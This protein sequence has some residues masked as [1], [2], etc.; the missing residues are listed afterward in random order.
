[1]EREYGQGPDYSSNGSR[2]YASHINPG[3]RNNSIDRHVPQGN[4]RH[5]DRDRERDMDDH[6]SGQNQY[7]YNYNGQGMNRT[8][9]GYTPSAR[10]SGS[11]QHFDTHLNNNNNGNRR[12][13]YNMNADPPSFPSINRNMENTYTYVKTTVGPSDIPRG[14]FRSTSESLTNPNPSETLK[15]YQHNT[16]QHGRD[17]DGV[18][19]F[20]GDNDYQGLG[21]TNAFF[22]QMYEKLRS[23]QGKLDGGFA[24]KNMGTKTT[25]TITRTFCEMATQTTEDDMPVSTYNGV[26]VVTVTR[27][28]ATQP[29]AVGQVPKSHRT[30]DQLPSHVARPS[31]M[32]RDKRDSRDVREMEPSRVQTIHKDEPRDYTNRQNRTSSNP[33]P[34]SKTETNQYTSDPTMPI[35][36][37]Y[38]AASDGWGNVAANKAV[39]EMVDW[40][41][42]AVAEFPE[43]AKPTKMTVTH[44][45]NQSRF[46]KAPVQPLPSS[47]G[48]PKKEEPKADQTHGQPSTSNLSWNN[49]RNSTQPQGRTTQETKPSNED[50]WLSDHR[51]EKTSTAWESSTAGRSPQDDQDAWVTEGSN[52]NRNNNGDSNEWSFMADTVSAPVQTT[53]SRD[54]PVSAAEQTSTTWGKRISDVPEQTSTSWGSVSASSPGAKKVPLTST[55]RY[56]NSLHKLAAGYGGLSN[57][58]NGSYELIPRTAPTTS[59]WAPSLSSNGSGDNQIQTQ[60][61]QTRHRHTPSSSSTHSAANSSSLKMDLKDTHPPPVKVPGPNARRIQHSFANTPERESAAAAWMAASKSSS[62][63]S[64]GLA[65]T[66]A[67]ATATVIVTTSEG[68]TL[69]DTQASKA[70]SQGGLLTTSN[71]FQRFLAVASTFVPPAPRTK[72]S[73][74]SEDDT[75]EAKDDALK[76]PEPELR[77]EV[78]MESDCGS[79][80]ISTDRSA[81]KGSG[82][83]AK[84]TEFGNTRGS[85]LGSSKGLEPSDAR[86]STPSDSV[87]GE[88]AEKGGQEAKGDRALPSLIIVE[89]SDKEANK[90]TN[91]GVADKLLQEASNKLEALQKAGVVELMDAAETAL[92]ISP[93]ARQDGPEFKVA[94]EAALL[95]SPSACQATSSSG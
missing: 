85:K 88:P 38:Q 41:S 61:Q 14:P 48:P 2:R 34:T 42:G 1:M 53:S 74:D 58:N 67:N 57:R 24:D 37:G 4:W 7:G 10:G 69:T 60:P 3:Y 13:D 28:S 23:D 91:K 22:D 20:G 87:W 47:W 52:S 11:I 68:V 33:S 26:S 40:S 59:R 15:A 36:D 95:V 43:E 75:S 92:P 8:A 63:K 12:Q 65:T 64:S 84:G 16:G 50:P 94:A 32:N 90:E 62:T 31:S 25:K 71:D 6:P 83:S 46:Q 78:D 77:E 54:Q 9:R 56:N 44:H 82:R 5:S 81:N 45:W 21:S 30:S 86:S 29:A 51:K 66:T 76:D 19:G 39:G 73:L 80:S 93:D 79:Q 17:I 72:P 89:E 70:T 35:N 55:E 18:K 27:T 49:Q